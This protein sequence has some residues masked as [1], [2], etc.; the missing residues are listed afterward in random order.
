M[1]SL[2][3]IGVLSEF[4]ALA[5]NLYFNET[6]VEMDIEAV[7]SETTFEGACGY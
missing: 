2:V 4:E 1:K 3:K 6:K 5:A 7:G